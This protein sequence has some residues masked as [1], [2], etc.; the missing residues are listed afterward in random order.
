MDAREQA[1]P[2][3]LARLE[4]ALLQRRRGLPPPGAG[5]AIANDRVGL[6][7]SGGGIRSATF[8]LG[9]FQ[10]LARERLLGRID[11]LSTVSGGGYFGSFYGRLLTRPGV[12]VAAAETLLSG[13]P[14]PE[15]SGLNG[16][17]ML[18]WLR[19]NGRYLAPQ[20]AGDYLMALTVL[21]RN[22]FAV[23]TV[24]LVSGLAAALLLVLGQAWVTAALLVPSGAL[25]LGPLPASL[26]LG[27]AG[28]LFA[29]LL[30][31]LNWAYWI[32]ALTWARDGR[33][34][35]LTRPLLLPWLLLLSPLLLPLLGGLLSLLPDRPFALPEPADRPRYL[36]LIWT[37]AVAAAGLA[38]AAYYLARY[39]SLHDL[40][41][42]P[43]S[44]VAPEQRRDGTLRLALQVWAWFYDEGPA[45]VHYRH[46][47]TKRLSNW[48]A[49]GLWWTLLLVALGLL[50]TLA[51][52]VYDHWQRGGLASIQLWL[53]GL[54]AAVLGLIARSQ[55]LLG[56]LLSEEAQSR[57]RVP[58]QWL[59]AG[60]G[61]LLGLLVT[62]ILLVL[63]YGVVW[64]RCPVDLMLQPPGAERALWLL[65]GLTALALYL[66]G[67]WAFLN[68]STLQPL[69][70][71]R[72]ARAYLGASNPARQGPQA[73]P[74]TEPIE[75][76]DLDE[77]RYWSAQ[78]PVAQGG[79][80]H[81][82]NVTI[83]ETVL[84]DSQIQQQD[85]RGVPL[86][87]G[88]AG[89]SVGVRHHL[90]RRDPGLEALPTGGHQVFGYGGAAPSLPEPLSLGQWVGI[91][92]AAFTTG[93]GFQTRFGLSLLM[94][95]LNVRL[96]YW[97]NSG[98]RRRGQLPLFEVQRFLLQEWLA[99]FP[100]THAR[101]W[102][103]SDGGHFENTAA[104]ELIRR[105]LRLIILSD[106][107]ADPDYQFDDLANLVRKARIDFGAELRFLDALELQKLGIGREQGIGSLEQL[108]TVAPR[109]TCAALARVRYADEAEGEP[110]WLLL[111]KPVLMQDLDAD[112]LNYQQVNPSFPNQTTVDQFF[113]EAQWES[114]RRLGEQLGKK[115]FGGVPA[116]LAH[117]LYPL[118]GS[119]S[120]LESG[121]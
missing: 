109:P 67:Q 32:A 75:G 3:A 102:P 110:H 92:G 41:Q 60:A 6:A 21:L 11:Y 20:G 9:L 82:V 14:G 91:S 7:L 119:R 33:R 76:D 31:P 19:E 70:S 22:W 72:L 16:A 115:L 2:A 73:R 51:S 95:L 105:R 113:D 25:A 94:G 103:L 65:A 84:G 38:L 98:V 44:A 54:L 118:L 89:W 108:R 27:L 58:L 59:A 90:L 37:A 52:T 49:A 47:L 5:T 81:L 101:H 36:S 97:W 8:S 116:E 111:I 10:A 43:H 57:F 4:A 120:L 99:R 107:G 18:R 64:E 121:V 48:L 77:S 34:P 85:R 104:Y 80:L 106:A 13:G 96:G 23:M 117:P 17:A 45:R 46:L 66:G 68:R 28:V 40:R 30:F 55:T 42:A 61:V 50:D 88:P 69:Y 83:N 100:G 29:G 53:S 74:V 39:R 79:P 12:D 87:I 56:S 62:V 114:Y 71:A 93:M 86:A 24:M 63:A 112:L 26:W 1:F 15:A 35:F 78:G